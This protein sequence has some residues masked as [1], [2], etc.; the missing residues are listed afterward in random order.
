MRLGT[1][2]EAVSL[3]ERRYGQSPE[4]ATTN[5]ACCPA[6]SAASLAPLR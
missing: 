2:D 3:E 6:K 4:E 5:P 1:G